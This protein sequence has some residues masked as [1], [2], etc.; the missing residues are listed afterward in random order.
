[1]TS[2]TGALNVNVLSEH[3]R[4]EIDHWLA[5]YPSDQRQSAV[6][7]AL[8]A[9]QHEQGWLSNEVMDAVA[10]YIGM[11][12]IAVYE[13]ASFYSLYSLKPVGRHTIAVCLNVSCM[14]RDAD[15]L[16]GYI[17]R[18]LGIKV[19]ESTSDGRFYLK[20][21]EECLAAC[22]GAPMMQVDHVYYEN[23][24]PAKVDEILDGLE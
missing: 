17:E 18:K 23:L 20:R 16:L 12:R 13:V 14:L 24:T 1:M 6:L 7:A 3:V 11:P 8:R 22:A 5:R 19:G 21:E 10:D 9:V 4:E 15:S 2:E